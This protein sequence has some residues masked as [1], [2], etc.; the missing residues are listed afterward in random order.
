MADESLQPLMLQVGIAVRDLG[1][2]IESYR[3]VFGI[4]SFR[5]IDVDDPNANVHAAVAE[6]AG[7]EIE[8]IQGR[9]EDHPLGRFLGDRPAKLQ[10]IGIYVDD[11]KAEAARLEARGGHVLQAAGTED[12]RSILVDVRA[13]TGLLIELLEGEPG[14][15]RIG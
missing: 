2:A 5:K 10:H 3:E 9:G 4:D 6:L 1:E 15:R 14:S 12:V 11:A 13:K 8:L 7:V